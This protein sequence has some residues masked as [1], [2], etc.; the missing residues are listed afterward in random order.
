[1]KLIKCLNII[2]L[3]SFFVIVYPNGHIKEK[4]GLNEAPIQSFI[5]K[6]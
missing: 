3:K 6:I 2:K 4:R 1:M 5:A